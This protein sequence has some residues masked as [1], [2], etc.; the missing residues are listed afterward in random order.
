MVRGE[1]DPGAEAVTPLLWALI[2]IESA[3]VGLLLA[4]FER[5]IRH[6]ERRERVLTNALVNITAAGVADT[7]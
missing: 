6:L 3:V 1:G 2:G 5:R 4:S 7:R